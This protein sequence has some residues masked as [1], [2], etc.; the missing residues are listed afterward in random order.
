MYIKSGIAENVYK[1]HNMSTFCVHCVV[2]PVFPS[3]LFYIPNGPFIHT[4]TFILDYW[5]FIFTKP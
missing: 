5:I 2:S 1:E 4:S 3:N